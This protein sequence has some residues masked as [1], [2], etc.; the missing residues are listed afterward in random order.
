MSGKKSDISR[1]RHAILGV[2]A[3][4][5]STGY[6]IKKLLSETTSHFWKESYGQIYPSLES[7]VEEGQIEVASRETDGR[8]RVRYRIL[9]P[10]REELTSWIRSPQFQMKPG[11]NELLLKLFFARREDASPLI[12]QVQEY[13]AQMGRAAAAYEAFDS[14][15]DNDDIQ[16]DSRLLIGTT[17]DYG[18]EA[19]RMQMAWCDRTLKLLEGLASDKDIS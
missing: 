16:P 3:F 4:E 9:P 1:T 6:E 13:R 11:R 10:G 8:E 5:P 17:I 18:V 7:L 12:H 19:A 14:D 15:T 2:L